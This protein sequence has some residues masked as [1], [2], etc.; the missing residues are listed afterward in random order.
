MAEAAST[1][2]I[3]IT[4]ITTVDGEIPMLHGLPTTRP[5][6]DGTTIGEAAITQD[7]E[8]IPTQTLG[9]I[10]RPQIPGEINLPPILGEQVI[11][12]VGEAWEE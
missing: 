12:P 4:G 11:M 7:G 8:Q 6:K 3:T 1:S 5:I 10:S 9:L 2:P